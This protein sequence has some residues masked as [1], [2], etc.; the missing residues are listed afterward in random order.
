LRTLSE[1]RVDA[2]DVLERL[3]DELGH[4]EWKILSTRR[5]SDGVDEAREKTYW[6]C[7]RVRLL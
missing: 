4:V 3:S 1:S 2:G 6:S 5:V 7:R